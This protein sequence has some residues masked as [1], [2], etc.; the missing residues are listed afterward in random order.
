MNAARGKG[1]QE[2]LCEL[3]KKSVDRYFEDLNGQPASDLYEL[4]ISQVERPLLEIVMRETRGNVSRAA[5][6]LG[7]NRGTLRTRLNKYGLKSGK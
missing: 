7:M 1:G 3:V 2:P 4:V 6:M 5:Q